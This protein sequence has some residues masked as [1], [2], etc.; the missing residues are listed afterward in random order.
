MQKLCTVLLMALFVL[1]TAGG[2]LSAVE[3]PS[4]TGGIQ[5]GGGI[6][7]SHPWGGDGVSGG[8]DPII[9]SRPA[10]PSRSTGIS[11]FDIYLVKYYAVAYAR[12]QAILDRRNSVVSTTTAS[13]TRTSRRHIIK[14]RIVR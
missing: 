3:D 1:M 9:D 12:E 7:R 10:S 2:Q 11:L 5:S 8:E 14:K 6:D 13:Q 4:G